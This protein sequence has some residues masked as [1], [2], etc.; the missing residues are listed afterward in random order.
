[1]KQVNKKLFAAGTAENMFRLLKNE[2]FDYDFFYTPPDVP[3]E[4]AIVRYIPFHTQRF[5]AWIIAKVNDDNNAQHDK[6]KSFESLE[7]AFT[8]YNHM[9]KLASEESVIDCLLGNKKA[10]DFYSVNMNEVLTH[11]VDMVATK[12]MCIDKDAYYIGKCKGNFY[13]TEEISE[14]NTILIPIRINSSNYNGIYGEDKRNAFY[15]H[16]KTIVHYATSTCVP[17]MPEFDKEIPTALEFEA[18]AND[19]FDLWQHVEL[20]QSHISDYPFVAE[21]YKFIENHD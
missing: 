18:M 11:Y 8:S 15:K 7:H 14:V 6:I 12:L 19:L 16:L 10:V 3:D 13:M 21:S 2:T 4:W 17:S 20:D 1:M 9:M 5:R